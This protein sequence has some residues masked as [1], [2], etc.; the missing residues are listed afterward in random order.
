MKSFFLAICTLSLLFDFALGQN[1]SK[2]MIMTVNGPINPTQMG[3][4]LEHEH[5]ATDFAGA[6][7]V[8]QPQYTVTY[9]MQ[10]L[11]SQVETLKQLGVQTLIECTPN[12][13]GR[14]VKLLK[15]LSNKLEINIITNTGYY[16]AVNKKYLPAHTYQ[17]SAQQLAD[18]WLKE[19]E[20]GIDGTGIRPGFVKLGVG[21]EK[22]DSIEQ[23]IVEAGA[24][25]HLETGLK[26]AI[27]TGG[28]EA[29]K[30]EVE[31][32]KSVGVN[33]RA[34][35][36]VHSQNMSV[37]EQLTIAETG[38]WLSLDGVKGTSQS[39]DA[40]VTYLRSLKEN[41]HL[42]RVLLS[43][44][45]GWSVDVNN[46][47][48][49]EFNRFGNRLDPPYSSISNKLIPRLLSDGFSQ[50]EVDQLLIRNPAE[51]FKI[52]ICKASP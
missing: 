46:S 15:A 4:T 39:I 3:F 25:T 12:Y 24:L 52:E 17:E 2:G 38:A 23:K 35:I 34:L 28:F 47:G 31:I 41:G 14:D 6:E 27:H 37:Q 18:R 48:N 20:E 11:A 13:I 1:D 8:E 9:A 42:G 21:K 5:V 29:A 50:D 43:H 7:T 44:D 36:V 49:V 22:L 45:D 40:Y 16:A 33:T 10:R 19:W 30:G 51:A 32:F 26:V